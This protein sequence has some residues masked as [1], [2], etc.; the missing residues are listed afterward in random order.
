M[1][2]VDQGTPQAFAAG[3]DR[4]AAPVRPRAE[5]PAVRRRRPASGRRHMAAR[6]PGL[7]TPTAETVGAVR[8]RR[9]GD[10][11]A[12]E[13]SEAEESAAMT[14]DRPRARRTR[15]RGFALAVVLLMLLLLMGIS[16]SI[17]SSV[18]SD[19][20]SSGAHHRDDERLL[21]GRGRHQ[22]R[23]GRLPEHLPELRDAVRRRLQRAH[24]HD[25]PAQR[26]LPARRRPGNPRQVIVPGG[27]PFAGLNATE[28]R[29]TATSTSSIQTGDVG[30]EHRHAVQRRLRAR[31]SSS[32]RSIRTTSRSCPARS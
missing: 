31:C 27:H 32:S 9:P 4:P 22:S 21:R 14:T 1:L 29:Y 20:V 17:H 11:R 15:Q 3:H 13:P 10:A 8:R 18:V 2:T 26:H 12:D 28:Y 6:E 23:H 16:A 30:G 24:V 19:T 7:V 25:R 5:L